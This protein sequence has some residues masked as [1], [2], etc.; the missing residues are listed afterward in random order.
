MPTLGKA[1]LMIIKYL[2]IDT[3]GYLLIYCS[4]DTAWSQKPSEKLRRT[5]LKM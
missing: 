2:T 5:T 1:Y 4:A 3:T